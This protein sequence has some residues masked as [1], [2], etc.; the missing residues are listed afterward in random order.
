MGGFALLDRTA[1]MSST[2]RSSEERPKKL[3]QFKKKK[4]T[5]SK[6][7]LKF[8]I[9]Q[10]SAAATAVATVVFAIAAALVV[11]PIFIPEIFAGSVRR[12][13][14]SSANKFLLTDDVNNGLFRA[15]ARSGDTRPTAD[16]AFM[17]SALSDSEISP[18][19]KTFATSLGSSPT[20]KNVYYSLSILGADKVD[21]SKYVRTIASFREPSSGWRPDSDRSATLE[22]T[23]YALESLK[24]L[25]E[26]STFKELPQVVEFVQNLQVQYD[27]FTVGFRNSLAEPPT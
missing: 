16:A 22:S 2:T 8:N 23:Y 21:K 25:G 7:E 3:P 13:V 6:K 27:N 1:V 9:F 5:K 15:S 14:K 10:S 24:L 26:L 4:T 17:G 12:G 18:A 11:A 20:M 19:L